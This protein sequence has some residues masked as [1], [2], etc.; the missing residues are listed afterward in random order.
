MR[1]GF[2]NRDNKPYLPLDDLIDTAQLFMAG[3][4]EYG[5]LLFDEWAVDKNG[6]RFFLDM[7]EI[8][9]FKPAEGD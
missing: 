8:V 6:N 7:K 4:G 2:V 3:D 9:K 1:D 5:I